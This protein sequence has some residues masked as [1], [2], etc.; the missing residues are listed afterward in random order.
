MEKYLSDFMT[1]FNKKEK[2]ACV[3]FALDGIK[4]NNFN[5]PDLYENILRPA[6]YSIDKC[7]NKDNDCIWKE[8][9]KTSI[10]RTIIEALYPHIIELKKE[11]KPLGIKVLLACPEREYHEIGLRM[12]SD[13]F[14]LNGYESIYIGSNTPRDQVSIAISQENPKYAAISVTD[15]F[16]LF[17]T[18]KLVA[19]IRKTSTKDIKIILGGNAFKKNLHSFE[20]IG[21]DIYLKSYK[22]IVN[23]R[24]EDLDEISI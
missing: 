3:N 12:M 1:Y 7:D 8:H 17:E 11:I 5:I 23:L 2:D 4:R 20:L 13:F 24:K 22:D 16:L 9:L 6:L 10:V 15:Y 19:E 18:K 21:G 14:I